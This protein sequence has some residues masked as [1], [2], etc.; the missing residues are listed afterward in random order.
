MH[1]RRI[2]KLSKAMGESLP[3]DMKLS[4]LLQAEQRQ[5]RQTRLAHQRAAKMLNISLSEAIAIDI[6]RKLRINAAP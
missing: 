2:A 1:L 5:I 4:D 6:E 3:S